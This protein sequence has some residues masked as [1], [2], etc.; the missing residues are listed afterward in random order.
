MEVT[1]IVSPISSIV[2]LREILVDL[3]RRIEDKKIKLEVTE[4]VKKYIVENV[5][6]RKSWK[7][8]KQKNRL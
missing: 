6:R 5:T 3:Q 7:L 2:K 1:K 8:E 4:A